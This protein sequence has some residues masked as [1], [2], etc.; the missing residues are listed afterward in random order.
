MTIHSTG[1]ADHTGFMGR[2]AA[3]LGSGAALG[4]AGTLQHQ[5]APADAADP[6]TTL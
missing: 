5:R 4:W 1:R 2:T 3:P 6:R